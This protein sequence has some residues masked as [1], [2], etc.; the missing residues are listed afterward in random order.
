M[1]GSFHRFYIGS[2]RL[3]ALLLI[4]GALF[5]FSGWAFETKTPIDSTSVA[6]REHARYL[7][8]DQLAGRGVDTPGAALARDYIASEFTKY[9]L[10]PAGADGTY[11]QSFDVATGVA[12]KQPT[13]L[14]LANEAPL[15]LNEAWTPLG[16][17]ASGKIEAELVFAGYGIT[18]KDYGYDDYAGIDARGK[19]VLVL[20]Y[21]PPP[22][23]ENSPFQKSQR[24][25]VH[26]TLRAKANNARDHGARGM[27]LVDLNTPG[28]DDKEL[29]SM[30]GSLWRS[31]NHL[32]A[33]Q[34]RRSVVEKWLHRYGISVPRLKQQIDREEKPASL[35]FA[36]AKVTLQVNLEE[37]HRRADNVIGILPGSDAKLK[38]ETIVVGAHYDHLGLGHFGTPDPKTRGQIHYGADDN[39]SGTAVLLELAKQLS[40]SK[41]KPARTIVFAAF[42]A[43][44]LGLH[45]SRHYINH[46]PVPLSATRAMINFDMVGRLRDNRVTVFGARSAHGLSEIINE[47]A[48]RLGL[49]LIESDNVGRSDHISFYNKKIPSFHFFTGSHADYHRPT[50]TWEKLNIEGMAKIVRLT[51]ATVERIASGKEAMNFVSLPSRPPSQREGARQGYGSYLGSI[52]DFGGNEEGVRLA[53]VSEGSPAALAGLREGDLIVQFAGTEVKN[54]EDLTDQL[55]NSK[56]GDEVEIVVRRG[57]ESVTVKAVLRSRS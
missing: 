24:Y 31:G 55:R 2:R 26:A 43:E 22:K 42:S 12:V 32:I 29:I 52:P 27:I 40:R 35:P 57:K 53:G 41:S 13:S 44:E 1:K 56:P 7:A 51:L 49:V 34:V 33:A 10:R 21:E 14:I 15:P 20:R 30:S 4:S 38:D 23:N 36:G 48:T 17:S 16:L 54:L 19:I 46:P 3:A 28:N 50:D 11:L 47:Q 37:I 6:L 18:V 45:G 9:G 39:A 25:S 8:S 5:C